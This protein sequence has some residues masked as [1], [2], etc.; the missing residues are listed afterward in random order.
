MSPPTREAR[1]AGSLLDP[2]VGASRGSRLPGWESSLGR[3]A[4]MAE[5][6]MEGWVEIRES[7]SLAVVGA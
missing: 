1:R 4:E 3:E 2:G 7:R 5:F 6:T